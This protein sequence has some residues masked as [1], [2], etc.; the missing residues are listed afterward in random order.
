MPVPRRNFM[1]LFGISLG[2]LLLTRCQRTGAPEPG[3]T[4]VTCYT[5]VHF[6]PTAGTP[7]PTRFAA[8]DRL[9]LCW[10]RFGELA[11]KTKEASDSGDDSWQDNPVGAQM[12]ADH[13]AALDE[14]VAAGDITAP[15]ADLI[16]EA[17]AA[18]VFHIWRSNVPVTCYEPMIVDYAPASANNLVLQSEALDQVAAG[19]PIAP[20]TLEKIRT[21]LEHDLAFYALTD[22]EVQALY[23]QMVKEYQSSG[24][25][26]PS[27]E[28]LELT[29]TPDVKTAAGFLLDVLTAK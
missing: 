10:L 16:Q 2:S 26:I 27:F 22:S 29:L 24:G 5:V 11:Q 3:S 19:T 18:A 14:L 4:Y 12:N 25:T 9:R 6:T 21:A 8:R 23:D 13:R 28:E 1:K 7:S 20:E 17:Y 15:V